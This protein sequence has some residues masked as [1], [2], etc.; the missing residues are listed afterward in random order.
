MVQ[1]FEMKNIPAYGHADCPNCGANVDLDGFMWGLN[2]PMSMKSNEKIYFFLCNLCGENYFSLSDDEQ[3]EKGKELLV[4]ITDSWRNGT[5]DS[6]AVTTLTALIANDWNIS[7]AI[8]YGV[9][10]SR[11]LHD[12]IYAGD[13]DPHDIAPV[14]RQLAMN[15]D[16]SEVAE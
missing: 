14:L 10:I 8:E 6:L 2:A 7:D 12:K 5:G 15:R 9:P 11:G 1:E 16:S 3:T 4:K 13:I